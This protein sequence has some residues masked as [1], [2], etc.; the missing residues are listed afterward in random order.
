ML[1]FIVQFLREM[2]VPA[3]RNLPSRFDI[4][5]DM[6]Y[7]CAGN[8]D[9]TIFM[10]KVQMQKTHSKRTSHPPPY[11]QSCSGP[12]YSLLS[13]HITISPQHLMLE[14]LSSNSFIFFFTTQLD[15]G[16][17][18][19]RLTHPRSKSPINCT[20]FSKDMTYVK[21]RAYWVIE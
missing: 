4:S 17:M 19:K 7:L 3:A 20:A 14:F 15:A 10:Y 16:T 11:F 21:R 6:Q 12:S 2:R 1:L 8:A 18:V 9:G 5:Q 13:I